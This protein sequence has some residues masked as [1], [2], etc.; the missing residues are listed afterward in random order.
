MLSSCCTVCAPIIDAVIG[1][2]TNFKKLSPNGNRWGKIT[3]TCVVEDKPVIPRAEP[4]IN[5]RVGNSLDFESKPKLEL[6]WKIVALW[7]LDGWKL[8]YLFLLRLVS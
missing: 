6:N 2:G 1:V 3:S 5:P 4:V 8:I 7:F